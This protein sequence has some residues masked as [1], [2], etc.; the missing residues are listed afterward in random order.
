M[1]S[2]VLCHALHAP[3]H[4]AASP[5]GPL[6]HSNDFFCPSCRSRFYITGTG[7]SRY[8]GFLEWPTPRWIADLGFRAPSTLDIATQ[9]VLSCAK[10]F[11]CQFKNTTMSRKHIYKNKWIN[12]VTWIDWSTFICLQKHSKCSAVCLF[13][14]RFYGPVNPMGSCRA[15]SVYLTTCLL[16]RLSPLSG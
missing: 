4:A 1:T 14:M 2:F 13:V 15:W 3:Q 12:G 6:N 5:F 7:K 8:A 16:G 9:K 11:N 10:K